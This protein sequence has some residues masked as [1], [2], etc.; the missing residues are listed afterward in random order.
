MILFPDISAGTSRRILR[1]ILSIILFTGSFFIFCYTPSAWSKNDR[2]DFQNLLTAEEKAW[3]DNHPVINLGVDPDFHPLEQIAPDGSYIGVAAD[4][5]QII[6]TKLGIEMKPAK[7]ISWQDVMRKARNREL[8]AVAFLAQTRQREE[9]LLFTDSYFRLPS[10]IITRKDTKNIRDIESIHGRRIAVVNGYWI[11][12]NLTRD[13]IDTKLVLLPTVRDCI[14]EVSFGDVD[15]FVGD[16]ASASSAI[17]S[18]GITNLTVAGQSPY[19]L[20]IRMGVRRDWPEFV[21]ILNKAIRS[22][23]PG[24]K[25]V[26]QNKWIQLGPAIDWQWIFII[27]GTFSALIILLVLVIANRGLRREINLREKAENSLKDARLKLEKTVE[28]RTSELRDALAQQKLIESALIQ[29]D[30]RLRTLVS[31]MH[32]IFFT[33]DTDLRYTEVYGHWI[34]LFGFQPEFFLGKNVL[35]VLGKRALAHEHQLRRVLKGETVKFEWSVKIQ[36]KKLY[37]DLLLS[38]LNGPDGKITGIIGIGRDI[39]KR[40][41]AEEELERV[42]SIHR[43]ILDN[44]VMGI[45]FV[46]HRI[47]E[48]VND[49]V[50]ELMGTTHDMING[51]TTRILYPDDETYNTIGKNAYEEMRKGLSSENYLQLIRFDN[52][53][54]FWCRFVGKALDPSNPDEGSIWIFE[55]VTEKRISEEILRQKTEELD[56]FFAVTL[57]LLCIADTDGNFRRLN[58]QWEETLGYTIEELLSMKFYDLVH[59]DDLS[60]TLDVINDLSLQIRVSDFTNRYRCKNGSYRWIEWRSFPVG[61]VIY[62]AARDITERIAAEKELKE[63]EERYRSVFQKNLAVMLL[64]DYETGMIIDA[65]AAAARYYGYGIEELKKMNISV[66]NTQPSS[67]IQEVMEK[68][69]GGEKQHFNFRHRLASGEIRDVEIYSGPLNMGGKKLL[70]SII[71]DITA[72]LK[73][74]EALRSSQSRLKAIFDNAGVGIDLVAN[75]G[76]FLDVNTRL[77]EMLG[78]NHDELVR[79]NIIDITYKDDI[80]ESK[81]QL[82]HLTVDRKFR[83]SIE[84]RYVKKD[85]SRFWVHVSATSISDDDGKTSNI[86]GIIEDITERKKAE[87]ELIAARDEADRANRA[88]S[89]FLAN[90]SH[91]IRTPLNAVIGFSELLTELVEGERAREYLDG[92]SVSGK[93]LLRLINDILDLS[94]IEAGRMQI[95]WHPVDLSALCSE[96]GQ[97]FSVTAKTRNLNFTVDIDSTL[98]RYLQIDETRLRQVLVNLLGNAF[99]FTKTGGVIL[100]IYPA[101]L[102]ED[103]SILDLFIE[104]TDT[105]IGIPHDEQDIIFEAFRQREGQAIRTYGGTGLGLTISKKFVEMMKG[106]ISLESEPDKGSTFRVFLPGINIAAITQP[107]W[108]DEEEESS[109]IIF[110]GEKILLVED[111][112]SNR[113]VV[114]GFLSQKKLTIIEAG[115]GK[116]AVARAASEKPD[117]IL[118]DIRMPVM[119]GYQATTLIRQDPALSQIPVIALTASMTES[120]EIHKTFDSYLRKPIS[121]KQLLLSISEFLTPRELPSAGKQPEKEST[122][123]LDVKIRTT[124]TENF[125]PKWE[126]IRKLMASY[127]IEDFAK[128]LKAFGDENNLSQIVSYS[129]SLISAVESFNINKMNSLFL[130]FPDYCKISH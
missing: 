6:G 99:K 81:Q 123:Q 16:I 44:N 117:C 128:Q 9:Y 107:Q 100:K 12:D 31:S 113:A 90:M 29:S 83:Y 43:L 56:Q 63:N 25:K 97:I 45:G 7:G 69:R 20:E 91:E 86:I 35:E 73:A 108:E 11:H 55:D 87:E 118:M 104:V 34:E 18:L 122:A 19:T 54:R 36:N 64:I 101:F 129:E 68:S 61:N 22:I 119:D 41:Q 88:K 46:R 125:M 66:I 28:E 53:N 5:M 70:Y 126:T 103:E 23:S 84:K 49:K 75:D 121:K 78:Y 2:D 93:T 40:K 110:N 74:E 130:S 62:A 30:T 98:P 102:P 4:Y 48:W 106:T 59:P 21:T 82:H 111:I 92:I 114:R 76:S 120:D 89:E 47:F 94:K 1:F 124:L 127:D 51:K 77:A 10:V 112:E 52:G 67:H 3:L 57:D 105:G 115:N 50:A 80:E 39:T 95:E 65:N 15:A 14:E 71:H 38:P 60:R 37:F 85:G 33:F 79:M 26:I 32:D 96:M 116:E 109:E 17:E 72:R 42:Y 58:R 27:A 8:D 24:Q 13:H